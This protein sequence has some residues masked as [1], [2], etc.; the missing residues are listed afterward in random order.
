MAQQILCISFSDI[1][2]DSRVLR[3]L[4]L[5]AEVGEVTTLSYGA[6]PP[7]ATHHLEIDASLPSL[8]QT[9]LGVLLLALRQHSAVEL[10]APA[11]KQARELVSGRRFD[12]V[13]ANEARALPL[14]HSV[15][16]GAPVWGDM[17]EWA[18]EERSHVLPWRLL[19]A[20]YMR[21]I[22]AKYLPG[23]AAVTAV[24]ASIARMYADH[25][26]CTVEVIRNA[27]PFRQLEPSAPL[28]GKIRL[29]H[30][31]AAVPG[32]N[33]E[34][35]I[36]A[37]KLLDDRFTL[38]LYLVKARD[39]GRY[40]QQLRD[41]ADGDQRI[42]FHD[43]VPPEE[44]P[45][46]LNAYDVGVFSLP[47]QTMNHRLMLPNKFFDFVQARLAL[48]FSPSPETAALME[49]YDLGVVTEDFSTESLVRA[50]ESLT[51][52]QVDK[53]KVNTHGAAASLSSADDE[54]VTRGVLAALLAP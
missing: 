33:L 41:L 47:P 36:E 24:N 40:W 42:T 3:Q 43:A 35:T 32:R 37:V 27:G 50:L 45:A 19:V 20:P 31:G 4:K 8:P 6:R 52:E 10:A 21:S 7:G 26:G 22:C 23:T 51:T 16:Q 28:P 46:T 11:V 54:A 53:Y 25:F 38:D 17:H 49:A 39:G 15:A 48:V 29:V 14:A 13:V 18:P 30:S 5:L 1:Q 44:L 9:P 34:G 2:A 12:L